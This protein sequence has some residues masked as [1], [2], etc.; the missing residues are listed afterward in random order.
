MT[1]DYTDSDAIY[2]P[3]YTQDEFQRLTDQGHSACFA[4]DTET[5]LQVFAPVPD[6]TDAVADGADETNSGRSPASSR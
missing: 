3:G 2:V 6:V 5:T 4:D 1:Q